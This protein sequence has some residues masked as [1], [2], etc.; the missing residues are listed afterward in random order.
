MIIMLRLLPT[1]LSFA[2]SGIMTYDIIVFVLTV[3]KATRIG[4]NVP[5]IQ[6]LIRDGKC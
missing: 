2:W 5:L 4:Y 1:V 6:V 3:Y